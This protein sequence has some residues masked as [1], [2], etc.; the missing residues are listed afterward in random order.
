T[1]PGFIK[2]TVGPGFAVKDIR[3]GY[4]SCVV[5]LGNLP[6]IVTLNDVNQL[7]EPF[8][9]LHGLRL[10]ATGTGRGRTMDA[11]AVYD[12]AVEAAQA[13]LAMHNSMHFGR[14]ISAKMNTKPDHARLRLDDTSIS[15]EWPAS[16]KTA[17][18]GYKTLKAAEKVI[19][20]MNNL[21]WK[22]GWLTAELYTGLPVVGAY[23]I[24]VKGLPSGAKLN[25]KKLFGTPEGI[26]VERPCYI[27][28]QEAE[29]GIRKLIRRSKG[30][31]SIDIQ[32]APYKD[33]MVHAI[34]RFTSAREAKRAAASLDTSNHKFLGKASLRACHMQFML[35]TLPKFSFELLRD[36]ILALQEATSKSGEARLFVDPEPRND[37][38]RYVTFRLVGI[39]S[40][41]LGKLNTQFQSLLLGETVRHNGR[42]AWDDFFNTVP[43]HCFLTT[44]GENYTKI[45]VQK[46]RLRRTVS[47]F[48]PSAERRKAADEIVAKIVELQAQTR[49]VLP[50]T[51]SLVGLLMSPELYQLQQKLGAQNALFDVRTR[52]FILRGDDEALEDARIALLKAESRYPTPPRADA[53]ECPACL[54]EVTSPVTLQCSHSWCKSCLAS[55]ISSATTDHK[56]FPLTCIGN[57]GQCE[58]I[59]PLDTAQEVLST[60]QFEDIVQASYIAHIHSHSDDFQFCPTPE[61]PHVYRTAPPNS[62]PVQCPCCLTHICPSCNVEEHDGVRCEERRENQEKLFEMWASAHDVKKCP[63]CKTPI[64]RVSGCHH[65]TCTVCRT[66]ICWVCSKSFPGGKG[67][68]DHMHSMHGGIG[69]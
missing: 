5:V 68:Y 44:L 39:T 15:L 45:Q 40:K 58:C 27:S 52:K 51:G 66:H 33:G 11:I 19:S 69:L 56:L 24:R 38:L 30:F 22:G 53:V 49:H 13:C 8:G 55:Y 9:S 54:N 16:Q 64:E 7:M 20:S 41:G 25:D 6:M 42:I 63:G 21:E 62:E 35:H 36:D 3:G 48:G 23:T 43:G 17:Y 60:S 50:L 61:C 37:A 46:D 18:L 28:Q 32:P 26:S 2:V 14:T 12:T 10:R 1:V 67:I 34:V 31:Q 29:Q 65:M 57:E 59:I 4:Q 47:L